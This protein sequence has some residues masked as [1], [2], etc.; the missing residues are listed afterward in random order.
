[1]FPVWSWQQKDAF[2]QRI[3][4]G[5]KITVVVPNTGIRLTGGKPRAVPPDAL[6]L[7]RMWVVALSCKLAEGL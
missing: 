4:D 3:F 1:M 7:R 6:R 5:A 2:K